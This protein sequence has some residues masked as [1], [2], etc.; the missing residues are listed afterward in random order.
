[1]INLNDYP[2]HEPPA[3]PATWVDMWWDKH[4]RLWCVQCKDDRGNQIG[5]AAYWPKSTALYEKKER[6]QAIAAGTWGEESW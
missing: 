3:G 6:E 4:V 5:Q 2:R 1:M